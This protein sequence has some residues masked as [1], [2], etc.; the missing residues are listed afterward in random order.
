MCRDRIFLSYMSILNISKYCW[1]YKFNLLKDCWMMWLLSLQL[2]HNIQTATIS[3]QLKIANLIF[4]ICYQ[5]ILPGA[6]FPFLFEWNACCWNVFA[7]QRPRREWGHQTSQKRTPPNRVL[8]EHI[9]S[10]RHY[11]KSF[12]V[13]TSSLFLRRQYSGLKASITSRIG[14]WQR[15]SNHWILW[16]QDFILWLWTTCHL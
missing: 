4:N 14:V 6:I 12:Q 13:H 2:L 16:D 5:V 11:I 7:D 15:K 3:K 8:Q 9:E 10:Q 1:I